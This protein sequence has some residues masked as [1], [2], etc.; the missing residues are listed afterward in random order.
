MF[1][2]KFSLEYNFSSI[3]VYDKKESQKK[4]Q[5]VQKKLLKYLRVEILPFKKK[6]LPINP[7]IEDLL[8]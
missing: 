6:V 1:K 3:K 8:V 5:F 4:C 2:T 7:W